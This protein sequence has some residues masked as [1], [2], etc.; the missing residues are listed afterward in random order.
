MA[1]SLAKIE[2]DQIKTQNKSLN[3]FD[4][5][6]D[7][8]RSHTFNPRSQSNGNVLIDVIDIS[9]S[10]EFFSSSATCETHSTPISTKKK[11][12]R[13]KMIDSKEVN[14]KEKEE[15]KNERKKR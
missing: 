9:D 7:L 12:E 5:K 6:V 11:G 10:E 8:E 15:L 4:E 2:A 3:Q 1:D 14:E 13:K